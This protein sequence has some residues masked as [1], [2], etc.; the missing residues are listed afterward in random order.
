[1]EEPWVALPCLFHPEAQDLQMIVAGL[2][3]AAIEHRVEVVT[4]AKADASYRSDHDCQVWVRGDRAAD[5]AELL[6]HLFF[7]QRG[8]PARRETCEACGATVGG[9]PR[10]PSC[11]LNLELDADDPILRFIAE[12]GHDRG[13]GAP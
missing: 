7:P 5:A 6:L 10:C 1:M 13:G 12:F 2:S 3:R 9:A 4:T 8:P 11:G